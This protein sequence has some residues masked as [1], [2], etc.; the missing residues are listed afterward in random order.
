MSLAWWTATWL[1]CCGACRF[2]ASSWLV[3][4]RK[5]YPEMAR[6][7]TPV[8]QKLGISDLLDKFPYEVSGGQK[9]RTAVARAL[10]A[11][12]KLVL[13]DEP[14]GAL[15]SKATDSLLRLF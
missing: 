3:L 15:D 11:T 13:A 5:S 7:L 9:Q 4:A 2:L 10:I 6:R 1:R 14:T 12:P 8:A